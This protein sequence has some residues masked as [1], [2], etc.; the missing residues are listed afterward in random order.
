[1]RGSRGAPDRI[2]GWE[3]AFVHALEEY[4]ELVLQLLKPRGEIGTLFGC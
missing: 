1:V 4:A 3:A 2:V